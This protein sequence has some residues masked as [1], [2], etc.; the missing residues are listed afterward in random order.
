MLLQ[1]IVRN[2]QVDFRVQE[3]ITHYSDY[4]WNNHTQMCEACKYPLN[5]PRFKEV[6]E[7]AVQKWHMA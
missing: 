1:Y 2:A 7:K 5:Q 6:C 3:D 4:T